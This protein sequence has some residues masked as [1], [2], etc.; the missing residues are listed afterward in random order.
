MCG[1]YS[2]TGKKGDELQRRMA[3]LLGASQPESDHGYERFNIA[4]TQEVLV[5]LDDEDGRRMEHVR[6]GLIRGSAGDAGSR[7]QMINA[8]AETLLD[9][10]AYRDLV[11]RAEHRCLVL[12]DGWYEWQRPEDPKL[13]RRALHFSLTGGGPFCFA[14]LWAGGASPSCTIV[15]CEANELARPIHDR[16]PVVLTEAG[17]WEAWLDPALDGAAA[18]ELLAPPGSDRLVVRPANPVVN[19]STS[20]GPECLAA[21][22]D[23]PVQLRLSG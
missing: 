8:R 5:A 16:M 23:V 15:T 3:E 4:P 2:N 1:R 13:Q 7:F 20:E 22:P 18:A 9:R 6:W 17:G 12:A 19:S 21:P 10:P 14:G 11:Q